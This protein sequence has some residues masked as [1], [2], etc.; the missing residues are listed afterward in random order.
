MQQILTTTI[1]NNG[2]YPFDPVMIP[3]FHLSR[4]HNLLKYVIEFEGILISEDRL[5]T[6]NQ[7][8]DLNLRVFDVKPAVMIPAD[9]VMIQYRFKKINGDVLDVQ[10]MMLIFKSKNSEHDH[11]DRFMLGKIN[12]GYY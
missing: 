4:L 1:I 7:L 6:A 5:H 9:I 12:N 10:M 2:R 8:Y 11:I 3:S